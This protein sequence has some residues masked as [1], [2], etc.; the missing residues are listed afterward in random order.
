MKKI[1]TWVLM[2]LSIPAFSQH[3]V[4]GKIIDKTNNEPLQYAVVGS[5]ENAASVI[6]DKQ[7]RFQISL[8]ADAKNLYVSLIGYHDMSVNI[9]NAGNP[10]LITMERGAVDLKE[11]IITPQSNNASFHTISS[12]DLNLRPVNSAQ[13]LMR[14]VPGLFLGEHH[15][16]GI[17][18][19]IFLRGFDADH[20]TDVNVSVDDMPLNLVSHAHGQ[21]F[22]DLHFLIPELVTKYEFG[23]GPYY[24]DKGDFTTAGYV[25]FHTVDVLDKST[26]KIEG[27]QFNTGRATAMINLLSD[28]AKNRGESAY[29][30]G[31]AAYTDGPFDFPQHFS[32]INLFGKYNVNL[33]SKE[34]LTI[35]LSTFTSKWRSSGAIPERAVDEGLIGRFGYIDSLQD[36][37]TN[38]TNIIARLSSSLSDKLSMENQIYYSRYHF[39]HHYDDTFFADDSVNG[40]R[41]KQH[42][43]RDLFGYNGKLT[44]RT[45]FKNNA[46]LTSS[47]GLGWQLNK[48]YN[49]ELSH[50]DN[51]YVVLDY[52]QLGNIDEMALNTY[53]D[54][55]LRVGKWLFNGG[56]RLDYL[57]F[58]YEDKLNPAMP[59]RNKIIASPKLNIEYTINRNV[60]LYVKTGKGFHS[61]DAKVVVGNEGKEILPAAYGIDI[62]MNW[63]PFDHLF[64]NAAVWYLYLQQ[65][66]VYD[67]D[68]GTL[69]PSDKTR[70]EGIDFSARYQF[71]K[72]LFGVVDV[73]LAKARDI[74]A[75]KGSDYIPLAV[76]FSSTGG[77]DFKFANGL[78]GGISY[79]YMKDRPANEDNSLVAKGYFVSDLTVYY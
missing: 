76:P 51:K 9:T 29:I 37:N 6:S 30:A 24:A 48:I 28:K 77:L 74:E 60:Q 54:E 67:G 38:R 34:R 8:P 32:R 63:K 62:G 4:R 14:L 35:T 13:D 68:E 44:H 36:G 18:E 75:P 47:F 26:V 17:A 57:Y 79:R 69:E 78:N 58:N 72:W 50:T 3:I 49:S 45:Y 25:A 23:K 41:L 59:S 20:G 19:H 21:G 11:V 73:N 16:G 27:G 65:E 53:L 7:G 66:F 46:D 70:R 33:S 22:S 1:Y 15:G 64:I 2:A 12:I 5:G 55:N 10:L 71:T 43:D 61:N 52:I 42:E 40:D 56:V 31:E 39:D